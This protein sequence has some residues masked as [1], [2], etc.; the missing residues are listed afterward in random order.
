M[1][2]EELVLFNGVQY[3]KTAGTVSTLAILCQAPF[4]RFIHFGLLEAS[5]PFP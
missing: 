5:H 2:V 3:K 1:E 4:P